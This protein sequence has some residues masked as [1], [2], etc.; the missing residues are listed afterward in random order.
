MH[1]VETFSESANEK[2]LG[3][4]EQGVMGVP[5][6]ACFKPGCLQF[7]HGSALLRPFVLFELF[8]GLAFALFCA[9]LRVSASDRV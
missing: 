6:P 3:S 9:H 7:L 5:K 1:T 4:P 8:C 2:L